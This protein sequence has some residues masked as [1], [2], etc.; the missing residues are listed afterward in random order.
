MLKKLKKFIKFSIVGMIWTYVYA[1]CTS[2]LVFVL[3]NFNYLAPSD[4]QMIGNF[5]DGGGSIRS[6]KDYI[7]M[8]MLLLII[9]FWIAGWRYFYKLNF[10]QLILSPIVWYNKRQIKKISN[11]TNVVL[12]NMGANK[13]G[14]QLQDMI[15][16]RMKL[17]NKQ[18]E[19][20]SLLI[21]ENVQEKI[22]TTEN[23]K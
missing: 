18:K 1:Y 20:T 3:W 6:G 12:K 4:W 23:K 7:F 11:T 19:P 21:R 5:W 22:S 16:D 10:I 2:L 13:K 9:P 14:P 17:A 15:A 8:T